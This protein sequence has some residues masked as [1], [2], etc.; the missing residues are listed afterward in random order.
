MPDSYL[1]KDFLWGFATASYQIEGAP[2][3]D[4]RGDSIWDTFCR[5]P[6][7]IAGG[8]SGDV[9]CDSYHRTGEDIALLK[10]LGAKSY[11]FSLS[12][13]RIIPLG[14]RNDPVNQKGIDHYVKFAKDLRAAGIEPMITLFHWDLPEGL[15]K[16]YGGL[17]NK[18]EFV[19]DFENYAR[20]CFKAFGSTVKLWITFN[21]PWCSSILGYSTGLFAPGRTSD[22]SKSKDG[23]SS[24]EPWIVGHNFLLAHGAAVKAYRDDFK[25]QDGGQ[26]GITLNGD[27][28]EPW[29]PEDPKDR[30]ACDRKIEFSICWFGD[31]IYFG[32]YPDSMRKQLGDRLPEFTP[33]E[34]A[35]VQGSNDFYGM[36]HYCANYIKHK[37]TEPELDDFAGNL[38]MLMQNKKGEWIGPETQSVWLRPMPLGFRKLIK[39]LSDRYGGP[40]FYVTENGTSLKGENE[41]PLEELLNDEFRVEYFRGYV[42]ALADAHALDGVDVRGY[43]AWSLMDNFEWAEGY[44]TRFGVTYVDYKGGQKRH[45][46]KS[47]R[48]I[49]KIFD[50]Y[51]KK[52]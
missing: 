17:L 26:I 9:A 33:E 41:L 20:V 11:R 51:I 44:T 45:P 13:S 14:G 7:K 29:D 50:Q 49:S 47:A 5:I 21:E 3:E 19:K 18:E 42:G 31:P 27:W 38:E 6:G 30:E 37:D 34:A 36:N 25:K 46:K 35:L 8:E 10:Q 1:P 16:R 32:K 12:W 28:T 4:G 22:R 43:S 40:T 15:D 52:D 48:E 23:D 39:W 2:A 24:R